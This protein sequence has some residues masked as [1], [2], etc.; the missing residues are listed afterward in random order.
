[1]ISRR[2]FIEKEVAIENLKFHNSNL[3]IEVSELRSAVAYLASEYQK[4]TG[5]GASL[6][7]FITKF[8]PRE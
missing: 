6:P 7:A 8:I 1:M 3:K 4:A 5:N 2:L